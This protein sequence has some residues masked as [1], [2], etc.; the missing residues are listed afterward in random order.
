V[1]FNKDKFFSSNIKNL[2]DN[3]LY[4]TTTKFIELIKC[5]VLL[6][7]RLLDILPKSTVEDN[8]EFIVLIGLDTTLDMDSLLDL[9]SLQNLN[10]TLDLNSYYVP[11]HEVDA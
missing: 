4:T 9:N 2:K 7:T 10:S 11:K 8:L 5:L 1:I 6:E 3:L